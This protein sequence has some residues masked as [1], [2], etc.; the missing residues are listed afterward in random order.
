MRSLCARAAVAATSGAAG[1]AV[2]VVLQFVAN[3]Q[4]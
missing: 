3:G 1:W 4:Q 2:T